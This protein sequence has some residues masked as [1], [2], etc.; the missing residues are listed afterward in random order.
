[1]TLSLSLE[2][3]VSAITEREALIEQANRELS[4]L[5]KAKAALSEVVIP[6]VSPM[7]APKRE[8]PATDS[9][10]ASPSPQ[11]SVGVPEE[12]KGPYPEARARRT[13]VLNA[14]DIREDIR[15]AELASRLDLPQ[16]H[17]QSD[18]EKLLEQKL[19]ERTGWGRWRRA[20]VEEVV[21]NGRAPMVAG[22]SEASA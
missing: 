16:S 8:R 13:R 18:L 6:F 2:H 7:R 14:L 9:A 12:L 21:W 1:M 4:A 11:P 17:V 15:C 19:V 20:V 22:Q 5:R 10:V 3:I